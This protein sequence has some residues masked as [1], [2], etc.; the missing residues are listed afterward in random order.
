MKEKNLAQQIEGKQSEWSA[1]LEGKEKLWKEELEEK[2][3]GWKGE[4]EQLE[5]KIQQ[6][7]ES[8]AEVLRRDLALEE[9]IVEVV[10]QVYQTITKKRYLQQCRFL[11]LVESF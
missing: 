10:L 6:L 8:K 1:E 4:K 5:A 9:A 11:S 3:K 2:E 7:Q